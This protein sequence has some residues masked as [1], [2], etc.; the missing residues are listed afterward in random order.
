MNYDIMEAELST[1][2]I[3]KLKDSQFG[4]PELRKYPLTDAAHVRS[5][6]SYFHKAPPGKKRALA[7]RIKKAA[8]KYGVE[9][10]PSSEVA[11]YL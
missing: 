3:N 2:E 11:Q 7:A 10:D 6:I 8:N 1:K 9:I 4:I 5:A